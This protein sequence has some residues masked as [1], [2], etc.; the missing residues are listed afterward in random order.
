MSL[1]EPGLVRR[2][3]GSLPGPED[4][5]A[6]HLSLTQT[7]CCVCV[8]GGQKSKLRNCVLDSRP[9]LIKMGEMFQTISLFF[10]LR[11]TFRALWYCGISLQLIWSFC[12]F[13]LGF[14][15]DEGDVVIFS[16]LGGL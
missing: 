11:T 8:G 9:S 15:G 10:L 12:Y 2:Q 1:Q 4:A 7:P 16:G 14:T 6:V 13:Y 3:G 5:P